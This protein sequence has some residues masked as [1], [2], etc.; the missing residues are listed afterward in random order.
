MGLLY[1]AKKSVNDDGISP[2]QI[3]SCLTESLATEDVDLGG[4]MAHI[5]EF[6]QSLVETGDSLS[7]L[8]TDSGAKAFISTFCAKHHISVNVSQDPPCEVLQGFPLIVVD[9][10]PEKS[11]GFNT[12][13]ANPDPFPKASSE[14]SSGPDTPRKGQTP[15]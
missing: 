13:L 12:P 4:F 8:G 6:Y 11:D 15:K 1:S 7:T 14:S 3:L 10:N 9:Q 2:S 5:V